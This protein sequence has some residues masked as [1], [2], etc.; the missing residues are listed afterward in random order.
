V[1]PEWRV[2]GVSIEACSGAADMAE[3]LITHWDWPVTLT[4]P[5]TAARMKRNPDHEMKRGC[6]L[7]TKRPA[8]A[9]MLLKASRAV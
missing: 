4:H 1:R 3:E 8:K 2:K 5:G 7:T 9:V 6:H